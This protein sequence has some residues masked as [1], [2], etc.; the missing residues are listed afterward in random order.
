MCVTIWTS[1][2]PSFF[3]WPTNSTHFE[4]FCIAVLGAYIAVLGA[5]AQGLAGGC[6]VFLCEEQPGLPRAGH[7]RFQPASTAPPQATAQPCNRYGGTWGE[8]GWGRAKPC[9]AVRGEYEKQPCEPWGKRE[10]EVEEVLQVPEQV[11][12]CSPWRRPLLSR[13]SPCSPRR[14]SME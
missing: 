13:L 7:S 8:S 1:S 3:L 12:H 9:L 2:R 6:G 10:E 4:A 14:T 5:G 11:F